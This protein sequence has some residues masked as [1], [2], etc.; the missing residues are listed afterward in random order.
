MSIRNLLTI[1][2]SLTLALTSCSKHSTVVQQSKQTDLG[3]VQVSNGETTKHDLGDGQI[4][5]MTPTVFTNGTILLDMK[6]ERDGQLLSKPR[7]QTTSGV[8]VAFEIGEVNFALTP[9]IKQ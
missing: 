1:L 9:V 8:A 4:C 6:V 7:I 5:T 3:V 2:M